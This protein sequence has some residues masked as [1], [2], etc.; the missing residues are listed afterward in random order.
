M[1][2]ETAFTEKEKSELALLKLAD[3]LTI[4][5]A[6]PK[7]WIVRDKSRP[8]DLMLVYVCLEEDLR[9]LQAAC[10]CLDG[11]QD[12]PCPHALEVMNRAR[13]SEEVMLQLAMRR[14]E[15]V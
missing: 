12:L 7:E 3:Q 1:I 6:A 4:E 13:A 8:D 11:A 2:S 9:T 5:M 14:P 15:Q 10:S